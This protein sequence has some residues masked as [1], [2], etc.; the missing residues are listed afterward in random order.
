MNKYLIAALILLSGCHDFGGKDTEDSVAGTYVR[1]I[2][3]PYATGN[4]T[5]EIT[6]LQNHTYQII[7]RSGY[8]RLVHGKLSP[9]ENHAEVWHATF[10]E[11]TGQ[12]H[13]QR[14]GKI[15]SFDAEHLELISGKLVYR[16]IK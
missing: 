5:L 7:K 9:F 8:R 2:D 1:S 16:K 14:H 4:D 11:G 6:Y 10:D 3:Q 15:F 12:L 13:E